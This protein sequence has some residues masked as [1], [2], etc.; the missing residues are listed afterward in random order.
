MA[1]SYLNQIGNKNIKSKHDIIAIILR[2]AL[3]TVLLCTKKP[4]EQST[5]KL[6]SL[7]CASYAGSAIIS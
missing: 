7:N 2:V 6:V 3:V 5:Q 4:S 1:F